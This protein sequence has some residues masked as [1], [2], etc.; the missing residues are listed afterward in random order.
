MSQPNS[1][2]SIY[3]GL[4]LVAL[5]SVLTGIVFLVLTLAQYDW[6]GPS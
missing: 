4:M 5:A 3:D 6:A 1:N 2:P